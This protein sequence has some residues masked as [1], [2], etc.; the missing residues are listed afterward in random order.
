MTVGEPS[1]EKDHFW[2][3]DGMGLTFADGFQFGC[4]F[5]VALLLSFFIVCLASFALVLLLTTL[6]VF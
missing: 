6:G 3:R 4:G 1:E 5:A 2:H